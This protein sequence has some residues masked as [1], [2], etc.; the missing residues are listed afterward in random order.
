MK[1]R[2]IDEPRMPDLRRFSKVIPDHWIDESWPQR[3]TCRQGRRLQF[4]ASQCVRA[5]WLALLKNVGSF[6]RLCRELEHL[7]D[8]RRFCRL[9]AADST[10]NA[11]CLRAFRERF[12]LSGWRRLH[13]EAI[14]MLRALHP[15]D[16]LGV[17]VV[18]SS[19]LPAAVRRTSK[20]G[21]LAPR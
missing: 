13:V 17:L 20:K 16:A 5:H 4:R 1:R 7:T 9:R 12:G 6:N 11:E 19:D 10:P 8:W 3:R 14:A 18:D 2:R 15:P 21:A